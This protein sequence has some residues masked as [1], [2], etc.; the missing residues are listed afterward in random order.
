[1]WIHKGQDSVITCSYFPFFFRSRGDEFF[2]VDYSITVDNL[3]KMT[4]VYLYL[5]ETQRLGSLNGNENLKSKTELAINYKDL[6]LIKT[7]EHTLAVHN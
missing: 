2:Y 5:E 1:M 6:K 3:S 7:G 4:I